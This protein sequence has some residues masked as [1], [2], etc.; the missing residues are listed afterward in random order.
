VP[1]RV[2]DLPEQVLLPLD[3]RRARSRLHHSLSI[4]RSAARP[5]VPWVLTLHDVIPLLWPGDY[6]RTGV[7]HRLLYAGARRARLLLAPSAAAAADAAERLGLPAERFRTTP[8]AAGEAFAPSDPAPARA[9]LGLHGPYV[10]CVGGVASPDPVKRLPQLVTAF[11]RWARERGREETLVLTGREGSAADGL[12]ALAEREGARVLLSG[13]VPDPELAALY[14]GAACV[15]C[16]SRY[17]GFGL[18]ALEALACGTPVAAHP[19]GALPEVAAHGALLVP[20]GDTRALLRAV[21]RVC[22]EPSLRERLAAEGRRH[23]ATYSWRRT[24]EL[25]WDAY[26][27]AARG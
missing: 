9:R 13:F 21:E 4:Y 7:V 2:R 5:G 17:E 14:S 20:D 22:D 23:A 1:D 8:L 27:E 11:A 26:E 16:A 18:P 3:L 15:V 25:T 12:R 19:V 24:A 6:L 10:L